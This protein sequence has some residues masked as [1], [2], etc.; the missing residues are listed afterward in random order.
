MRI[1]L[2]IFVFGLPIIFGGLLKDAEDHA[3]VAD[4]LELDP[5]DQLSFDEFEEEFGEE[6]T[7]PEERA[8]REEALKAAEE[9]VREVNKEYEEGTKEWFERIN[10][11]SDL[12]EDEFEAERTGSLDNNTMRYG[13]GLLHPETWTPDERSERYFDTFRFDRSDS[14]GSYSSVELGYD[15]VVKNQMKCGSCVAFASLAA[16]EVCFKKLTGVEGDYSEQQLVDCGFDKNGA[17]GCEGAYIESYLELIVN[18]GLELTHE[19]T[20]PYL[21][22]D[23]QLTCPVV[24]PYNQGARVTDSYHT[25]EGSEEL[26]EK[27]VVEHGAVV[28]SVNT[29]GIL[30]NFLNQPAFQC[31]QCAPLNLVWIVLCRCCSLKFNQSHLVV[32]L[33]T[34]EQ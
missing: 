31:V 23:P 21:N 26:L 9:D 15:T 8:R 2:F 33:R 12:P 1:S 5:N 14:P 4:G 24:E 18:E 7:D 28:T 13:R 10:E 30:L 11:Y 25:Y 3:S 27:L 19:S 22:T 32:L 20:Y 17:A 34:I 29:K 6:I 16:V